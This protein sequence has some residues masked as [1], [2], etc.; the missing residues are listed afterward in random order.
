MIDYIYCQ[1]N[2]SYE[3]IA[4]LVVPSEII[5]ILVSS[6]HIV[7]C[8]AAASAWSNTGSTIDTIYEDTNTCTKDILPTKEIMIIN[9]CVFS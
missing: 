5:F 8:S 4:W 7:G 3:H 2:A 9:E 6:W 1:D